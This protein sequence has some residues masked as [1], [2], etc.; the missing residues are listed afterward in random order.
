[1]IPGDRP[2]EWRQRTPE[3]F[4]GHCLSLGIEPPPNGRP[5]LARLSSA[6][7]DLDN[8][9]A[10]L[11]IVHSHAQLPLEIEVARRHLHFRDPQLATF[12]RGV[13]RL[14]VI[15]RFAYFRNDRLNA[16]ANWS[17]SNSNVTGTEKPSG[18]V[19]VRT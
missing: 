7:H 2:A 11:V 8:H 3:T 13:L 4:R 9:F 1:V 14:D 18:T 6:E 12:G 15:H 16:R 5:Q 19:A 17:R 10:V